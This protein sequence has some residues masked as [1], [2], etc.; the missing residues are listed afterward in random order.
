MADVVYDLVVIGSGTGGYQGAIRA[1]QLGFKTALVEKD[2][3]LGGTCLNVGCIPSKALLESTSLFEELSKTYARHGIEVDLEKVKVDL[4]T[5][6]KRKDSIVRQLNGGVGLL[7]KKNKIDVVAGVG[8]IVQAGTVAV[9]AADGTQTLLNTK[10]ILIATG[11]VPSVIPGV[12]LDPER[13]G[14][15]TEALSYPEVPKNL[16]VIGAGVI[17]LELGSV[18]GRLGAK[19]T[20]VEYLDRILPGT[21]EELASAAFKT[22]QRQG[23][24]FVLGARVTSAR[25][26]ENQGVVVYQDKSGETKKLVGD[27][28]LVAVGRRPFTDGLG[29]KEAGIEIDQRGRIVISEH[30]QTTLPGVYAV[31]DCVR[32]AMLAH[33][34]SEEGIAAVEYMVT[35]VGHMNYDAVPA[36]TYTAPEIA[37]VGKTEEELKTAGIAYKKGVFPFAPIGRAKALAHTDGFV[38]ILADARTDR[39]LGGHIIGWHAGDLIEELSLAIEFGSSA[40]DV[41]RAVHAHPTLSEAV[42]EAALAVDNRSIHAG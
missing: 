15:S 8:R 7:M 39:I 36:I 35:G 38:K 34:A 23:I 26:E 24:T 33:K 1:A 32:G 13:V 14:T 6:L 19:V 12:V 4:P 16:I 42:K 37:S 41:A 21:D 20:V 9:I 17:G 11:S 18:W 30:W 29:A 28:V 3:N 25:A 5:M 40:E 27:R 10:R 31:G 2:P 22:F